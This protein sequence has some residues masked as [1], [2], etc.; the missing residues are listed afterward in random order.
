MGGLADS[1]TC[2]DLLLPDCRHR[3]AIPSLHHLD[4]W[5]FRGCPDRIVLHHESHR[6][7]N[8][9]ALRVRDSFTLH[10]RHRYRVHDW[11]DVTSCRNGHRGFHGALRLLLQRL[12]GNAQLARGD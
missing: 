2:K 7:S 1:V 5:E 6:S 8:V 4:V 11:G 3:Q 10:A 9:D 12:F